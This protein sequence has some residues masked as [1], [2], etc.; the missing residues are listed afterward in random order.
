MAVLVVTQPTAAELLNKNKI[1]ITLSEWATDNEPVVTIGSVFDVGGAMFEVQGA[2]DD[3]DVASAFGGLA[4]GLVYIYYP[5]TGIAYVSLTAP[6]WSDLHQEWMDAGETA[7]CIGS[8]NKTGAGVYSQKQIFIDRE[9][10]ITY[11]GVSLGIGANTDRVLRLA[12][13]ASILWDESEDELISDKGMKMYKAPA[14]AA[15]VQIAQWVNTGGL[16]TG[17]TFTVKKPITAYIA[18]TSMSGPSWGVSLQAQAAAGWIAVPGSS[19][20]T[21]GPSIAIPL[22]PGTFRFYSLGNGTMTVYC[23]GAYGETSLVAARLV[24]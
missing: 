18:C 10:A 14:G 7:R 4:T 13:D 12:S 8:V 23:I 22:N 3:I 1:A 9:H 2:D 5:G 19:M 21:A 15:D 20:A 24:V 11:T 17:G 16:G 6:T